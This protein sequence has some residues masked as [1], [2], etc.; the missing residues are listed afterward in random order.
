[1]NGGPALVVVDYPVGD[2]VAAMRIAGMSV[3]E[4]TLRDAAR[5]GATRA[6]VRADA[7]RLPTLPALALTVEIVAPGAAVPAEAVAVPG[8]LIGGVEVTDPA[9]ARAALRALL[10]ACRRP[11]DGVGDRYVVRYLS[12]TLTRIL[13]RTAVTPNHVTLANIAVGLA[14][15]WLVSTGSH[16]GV[17]GGG[18]LM[19]LQSV[20]DSCD[21]EL[22]RIRH[23]HSRTGMIMDNV[24]DDV[25]DNLFVGALG[26]GLG[27]VWAWLGAG[28]AIGRG[29]VA[30][31]VYVEIAWRGKGGDVMAFRWWFDSDDDTPAERF[32]AR[33]TPLTVIRALG[34]RD[35]YGILYGITCM[36]GLPAVGLV[37]GIG[38][39]AAS[40]A[41]GTVHVIMRVKQRRT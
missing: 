34:R 28:A 5:D 10:Q 19:F 30:T 38:I 1:M 37:L 8:N 29:L 15:C 14:A 27:G 22:A 6:I 40:F 33:V 9:S 35:L 26:F 41:M 2:Q 17:V 31:M 36:V 32:N 25:I 20:L 4:R 18:A 23:M 3:L 39:S 16:L 24:S 13:T 7:T 21:G 11:H 12:L